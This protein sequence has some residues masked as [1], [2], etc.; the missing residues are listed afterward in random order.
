M[1]SLCLLRCCCYLFTLIG[2]AVRAHEVLLNLTFDASNALRDSGPHQEPLQPFGRQQR[3][4]VAV[5]DSERGRVLSLPADAA[6]LELVN[7]R[8]D[9]PTGRLHGG[10]AALWY[11]ST[12]KLFEFRLR[13]ATT[14]KDQAG[15]PQVGPARAV[16]GRRLAR[17]VGDLSACLRVV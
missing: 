6:G 4:I 16:Q 3:N 15:G 10:L 9:F 14:Q 5:V 2:S 13:F 1:S 11:N 12:A 7:P 17:A 8:L